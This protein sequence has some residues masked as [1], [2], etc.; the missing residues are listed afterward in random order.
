M[1]GGVRRKGETT[2]FV[3]RCLASAF[4]EPYGAIRRLPDPALVEIAS[5]S[6]GR[7]FVPEAERV[8]RSSD[9]NTSV[10]LARFC[11]A[12]GLAPSRSGPVNACAFRLTPM[13]GRRMR[14]LGMR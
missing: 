10:S 11:G 14:A 5:P 2:R 6:R 3:E 8:C 9:P 4:A 12:R 7:G 13:G 1:A